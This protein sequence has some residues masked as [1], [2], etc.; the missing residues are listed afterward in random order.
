MDYLGFKSVAT[1][2][3]ELKEFP[4]VYRVLEG[5][6]DVKEDCKWLQRVTRGEKRVIRGYMGLQGLTKGYKGLLGVTGCYRD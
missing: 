2:Y 1:G 6:R 4:K 5:V 3:R